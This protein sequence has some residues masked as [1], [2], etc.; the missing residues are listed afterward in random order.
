MYTFK[1]MLIKHVIPKK[2]NVCDCGMFVYYLTSL[3]I[4]IDLT[5]PLPSGPDQAPPDLLQQRVGA[6]PQDPGLLQGH[7]GLPVSVRLQ[8]HLLPQGG[9]AAGVRR[10]QRGGQPGQP[11]VAAGAGEGL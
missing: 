6:Q 2:K 5:P 8:Q 11:R 3:I 1:H 4:R 7:P 10:G 9:R